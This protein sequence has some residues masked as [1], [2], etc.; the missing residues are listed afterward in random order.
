VGF[1]A[2]GSYTPPKI[3]DIANNEWG[4]KTRYLREWW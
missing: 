2:T 4:F 1:N 3:L